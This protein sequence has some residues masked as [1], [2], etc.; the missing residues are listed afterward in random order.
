MDLI[1]CL[2]NNCFGVPDSKID[3]LLST[4]YFFNEKVIKIYKHK[5]AFYGDLSD[6]DFRRDFYI[7]DFT[8]NNTLSPDLYLRLVGVVIENNIPVEVSHG[9]ATDFYIEM[10]KIDSSKNITNLL[11]KNKITSEDL[12]S[13]TSYMIK[14]I[15]VLTSE[16][17]EKMK[18]LFLGNWKAK[19]GRAH[20]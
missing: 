7:E 13:I 3:T 6:S 18:D 2:E 5:K 12:E 16:K 4:L 15:R 10:K 17:K 8:W 14:K 1:N 20:V 9:S 19:I 11:D